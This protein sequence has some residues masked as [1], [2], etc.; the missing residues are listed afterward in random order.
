M[1]MAKIVERTYSARNTQVNA[2]LRES[3]VKEKESILAL[4]LNTDPKH[5]FEGFIFANGK[6]GELSIH[7]VSKRSLE[8]LI[9][10]LQELIDARALDSTRPYRKK[11]TNKKG[12]AN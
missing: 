3:F 8:H 10:A 2:I 12:G 7:V 4:K 1:A 5:G 6:V 9:V 11:V